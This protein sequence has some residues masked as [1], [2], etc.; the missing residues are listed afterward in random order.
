MKIINKWDFH[1]EGTTEIDYLRLPKWPKVSKPALSPN[2]PRSWETPTEI[3]SS[4]SSLPTDSCGGGV[5][6]QCIFQVHV[7]LSSLF[8]QSSSQPC[9]HHFTLTLWH[10]VCPGF[11]LPAV[12]ASISHARL[13]FI[14]VKYHCLTFTAHNLFRVYCSP[15]AQNLNFSVWQWISSFLPFS[16]FMFTSVKLN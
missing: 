7:F 16:Y 3:R 4:V 15:S 8:L 2:I 9:P 1:K 13:Q 6:D 5:K 14:S 12:H 11:F 10:Q